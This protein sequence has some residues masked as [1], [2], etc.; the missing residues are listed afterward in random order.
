[1]LGCVRMKT[2]NASVLMSTVHEAS[3]MTG[4]ASGGS[5]AP[6]GMKFLSRPGSTLAKGPREE[7]ESSSLV[8]ATHGSD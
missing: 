6:V 7:T 1:M 5:G 4:M 8:H 2:D 3:L